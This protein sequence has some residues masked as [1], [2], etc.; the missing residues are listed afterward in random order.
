MADT[1]AKSRRRWFTVTLREAMLAVAVVGL[2]L[3]WYIDHRRLA[4]SDASRIGKMVLHSYDELQTNP[5]QSTMDCT[6]NRRGQP[7]FYV[8]VWG[9][10]VSDATR[11]VSD[12]RKKILSLEGR[13]DAL[14]AQL[15]R[16]TP[17]DSPVP[18]PTQP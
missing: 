1:P 13:R 2:S 8:T 14:R 6:V 17:E 18:P 9:K 11:R 5:S 15:P 4:K 7:T 16:E 10:E 12:L 3:A